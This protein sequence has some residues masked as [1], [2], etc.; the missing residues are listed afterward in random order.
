MPKIEIIAYFANVNNGI[1]F[2]NVL[3]DNSLIRT[4]NHHTSQDDSNYQD[5]LSIQILE[6]N[7]KKARAMMIKKAPIVRRLFSFKVSEQLEVSFYY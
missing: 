1:I 4:R 3:C 5:E 2:K 7:G 6:L